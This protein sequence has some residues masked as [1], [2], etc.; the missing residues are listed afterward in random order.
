MGKRLVKHVRIELTLTICFINIT[1]S[2]NQQN[3]PRG[4]AVTISF[5]LHLSSVYTRATPFLGILRLAVI[6]VKHMRIELMFI[7]YAS[8][9]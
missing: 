6:L 9:F 4:V 2:T 3:L 5:V 1:V 7:P 8:V